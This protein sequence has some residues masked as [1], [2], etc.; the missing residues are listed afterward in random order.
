M[1]T[2]ADDWKKTFAHQE[3]W[4]MNTAYRL[5]DKCGPRIKTQKTHYSR[6]D[7]MAK[8]LGLVPSWATVRMFWAD[9]VITVEGMALSEWLYH[10]GKKAPTEQQLAARLVENVWA[11]WQGQRRTRTFEEAV[12]ASKLPWEESELCEGQPNPGIFVWRD[13]P[14]EE[15][16]PVWDDDE[17]WEL[18][19]RPVSQAA[20]Y[21][22]G[23]ISERRC[24]PVGLLLEY[25]GVDLKFLTQQPLSGPRP[26]E[27]SDPDMCITVLGGPKGMTK[28]VILKASVR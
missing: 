5:F 28:P 22:L 16:W 12:A 19:M 20:E 4:I 10:L 1:P 27:V 8:C 13:I 11:F 15:E 18:P 26:P 3:I 21:Y 7:E 6:L 9:A 14:P 2:S 24:A 25:D 23:R 17:V